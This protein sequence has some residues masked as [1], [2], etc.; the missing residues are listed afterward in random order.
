MSHNAVAQSPGTLA[1]PPRLHGRRVSRRTRHLMLR[2]GRWYWRRR[3]LAGQRGR[4]GADPT[5]AGLAI[6]LSLFTGDRTTARVRAAFLDAGSEKATMPPPSAAAAAGPAVTL[7]DAM[8]RLRDRLIA[9]HER[10]RAARP[11][12]PPRAA[13]RSEAVAFP[14]D[15]VGGL[16]AFAERGGA[17]EGDE[18]PGG[19]AARACEA[20]AAAPGPPPGPLTARGGARAARAP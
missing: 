4:C 17:A 3:P 2:H 1:Q 10:T 19:L 7:R 15:L 13:P 11:A 16:V 14:P 6:C 12:D 18:L 8:A 20:L 9:E 5:G